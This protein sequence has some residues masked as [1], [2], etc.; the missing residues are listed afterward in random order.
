MRLPLGLWLFALSAH[1]E[2]HLA[3]ARAVEEAPEFPDRTDD[4]ARPT[5]AGRAPNDT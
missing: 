3:Q 1:E 4:E 2:R 5:E